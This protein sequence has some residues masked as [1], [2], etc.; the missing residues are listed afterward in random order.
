MG[1]LVHVKQLIDREG[2]YEWVVSANREGQVRCD[3]LGL[4][5]RRSIQAPVSKGRIN[6]IDKSKLIL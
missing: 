4:R 5:L 2:R 3:R 1:A 6:L